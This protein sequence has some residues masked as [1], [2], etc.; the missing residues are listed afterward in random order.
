MPIYR[1]NHGRME[2]HW[3]EFPT[4]ARAL[5]F[6]REMRRVYKDKPHHT[7]SITRPEKIDHDAKAEPWA[8][9]GLTKSEWLE[10]ME[11]P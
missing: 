11:T 7:V 2:P 4:W 3:A 1:V 5:A 9:L 10:W 8:H 6:G